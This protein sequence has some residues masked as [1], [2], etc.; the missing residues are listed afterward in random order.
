MSLTPTNLSSLE[1]WRKLMG[2]SGWMETTF[3]SITVLVQHL[4]QGFPAVGV[5]HSGE[6]AGLVSKH[7]VILGDGLS[8]STL[9]PRLRMTSMHS[10][11]NLICFISFF[12]RTFSLLHFCP[13][14]AGTCHNLSHSHT[15][16]TYNT[17]KLHQNHKTSPAKSVGSLPVTLPIP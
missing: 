2:E 6:E 5:E 15:T 1:S 7:L 14:S 9:V 13:C 16:I 4:A 17:K 11:V 12:S 8:G 10:A 3:L